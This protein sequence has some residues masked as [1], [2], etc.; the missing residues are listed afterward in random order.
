MAKPEKSAG[1]N[2]GKKN[3]NGQ[4]P[5]PA[6]AAAPAPAPAPAAPK[7]PAS[8]MAAAQH[9]RFAEDFSQIV[10][11]LMRAPNYRNLAIANLEW[12]VIPPLIAGQ[13]RIAV[14]KL[15]VDGP[16]VP[17]AVA[18]WARVSPGVDKRL[19]EKLDEAPMLRA[20]EWTSGDILWMIALV[21]EP[22]ALAKLLPQVQ[23][24]AFK[25]RPVKLRVQQPDGTTIVKTLASPAP[26]KA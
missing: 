26:A 14:S 23:K 10:A 3:G 20:A 19:S 18:L 15:K 8:A 1:K 17:V 22:D 4:T 16:V 11:V 12:L 21:G 2:G 13:S 9:N 24:T 7:V 25:G 5:K 6:E